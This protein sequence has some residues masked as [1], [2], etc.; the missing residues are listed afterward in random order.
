MSTIF[1]KLKSWITDM[2]GSLTTCQGRTWMR[3]LL[4]RPG[5]ATDLE[6]GRQEEPEGFSDISL[7]T[8]TTPRWK[9]FPSSFRLNSQSTSQ[10]N[11]SGIGQPAS[12]SS[13]PAT[14]SWRNRHMNP[15]FYA[16]NLKSTSNVQMEYWK[17]FPAP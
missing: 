12:T 10:D 14:P 13:P 4:T 11:Y 6:Q 16:G 3:P 7:G 17:N 8:G 9:W 5:S 1:Q 15:T 2:C